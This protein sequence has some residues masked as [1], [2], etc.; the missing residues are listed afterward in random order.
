MSDQNITTQQQ[1][2]RAEMILDRRVDK[3]ITAGLTMGTHGNLDFANL[4]QIME[5]ARVV[6]V[7]GIAI[8][9]HLRENVGACLAVCIQASEWEMSP[10]A[11]ANKTYVVNDRIAFEAQ[12]VA[13]V[14]LKRAPIV[15][16]IKYEYS[17]E[18]GKR[19]C[20]VSAKLKDGGEVEYTSPEFDKI[21]VKNS[22]LWKNDPDQQ[23][24]Y[25]SVR[26]M[27]RRHFPDVI[28]GVYTPEEM[29]AEIVD[30][31]PIPGRP[32]IGEES[33]RLPEPSRPKDEPEPAAPK[34][35]PETKPAKQPAKPKPV[36]SVA[37]QTE[38]VGTTSAEGGDGEGTAATSAPVT[39]EDRKALVDEVNEMRDN[40]NISM[41]DFKKKMG[42]LQIADP[43]MMLTKYPA[44]ILEEVKR[45][46]DEV[47]AKPEPAAE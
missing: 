39:E 10:F 2:S 28:L 47:T 24:G 7:A 21:P 4:N 5:V 32:A 9:K 23:T 35:K 20:T 42:E 31:T 14:I 29:A 44:E 8:P 19:R 13:A 18:G 17:G 15:G 37:A 43:A 26:A 16:R 1:P 33:A 38:A 30:V 25:Y 46:W 27:A 12:L 3:D 41:G 40:A 45:R 6:A 36:P 11:V 34:A 22:P